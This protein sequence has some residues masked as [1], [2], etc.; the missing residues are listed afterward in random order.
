LSILEIRIE[1]F[2]Q[3]FKESIDRKLVFVE[4]RMVKVPVHVEYDKDIIVGLSK[5][6]S[7]SDDSHLIS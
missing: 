2:L 7:L 1:D 5:F 4:N 6:S 3:V